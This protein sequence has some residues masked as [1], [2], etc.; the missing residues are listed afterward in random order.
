[1]WTI[2]LNILGTEYDYE[3]TTDKIDTRL[4]ENDGYCDSYERRI[5]VE[6]EHNEN[7]P[8]SI[9]NFDELRRKVKRHEIVHAYFHESGL[10][11]YAKNELIVDWIAHQFP[12]MLKT[13][14]QIDAL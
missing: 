5:A 12:K 6:G 8:G 4:C 10:Q 11:D 14:K 9:K 3:I 13:F 2:K 7:A 1:M